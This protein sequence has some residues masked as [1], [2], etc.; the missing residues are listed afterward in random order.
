M[1]QVPTPAQKAQLSDLGDR[2]AELFQ[3]PNPAAELVVLRQVDQF[4]DANPDVRVDKS[5]WGDADAF[6]LPVYVAMS[7]LPASVPIFYKITSR[8][9][10]IHKKRFTHGLTLDQYMRDVLA[11]EFPGSTGRKVLKEKLERAQKLRLVRDAS[12]IAKLSKSGFPQPNRYVEG[13]IASFLTGKEGSV[14]AQIS[15]LRTDIGM[16]GVKG[17]R[18]RK[19]RGSRR[20]GRK[21]RRATRKST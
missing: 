21:T 14:G 15:Q 6:D 7:K 17:A 8:H 4:L 11:P 10:D 2:L 12:A 20:G 5:T 1:T 16:P 13:Q 3:S 18:R 9:P 19:T